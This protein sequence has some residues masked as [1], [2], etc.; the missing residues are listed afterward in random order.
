MASKRSESE[1]EEELREHLRTLKKLEK[2]VNSNK[3]KI[4]MVWNIAKGIASSHWDPGQVLWLVE[5][6]TMIT[7]GITAEKARDKIFREYPELKK[8]YHADTALAEIQS[9]RNRYL[10]VK[11]AK[12]IPELGERRHV[13][14][15]QNGS[16]FDVDEADDLPFY[17]G[18]TAD[19]CYRSFIKG[20][21]RVSEA[22]DG[23]VHFWY[24][25]D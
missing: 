24:E 4:K 18:L 12:R 13:R 20:T 2:E 23:W 16:L 6:A 7:D 3:T 11:K 5:S 15:K 19:E 17:R 10:V 8:N 21:N 14:I 9:M 1:A 22:S 25:P